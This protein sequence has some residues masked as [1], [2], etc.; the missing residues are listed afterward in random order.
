MTATRDRSC[1]VGLWIR[2]ARCHATLLRSLR[3]FEHSPGMTM[4][5]FDALAQLSR[6]PQGMTSSAL[7]QALLVTAGNVTGLM[8]RLEQRGWVRR[9]S[10]P[11]DGRSRVLVLTPAGRK[12]AARE[13][14]R[15]EA[16]IAAA[17]AGL[18]DATVA[19]LNRDLERLYR[20]LALSGDPADE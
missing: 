12:V 7:A 19:R 17:L 16:Q 1:V 11:S 15:H 10:H 3:G 18:S 13:I 5:Q 14:A 4:A 20:S 2:L 6:H 8:Q 9:E